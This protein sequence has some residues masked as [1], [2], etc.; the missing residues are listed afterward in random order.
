MS[1]TFTCGVSLGRAGPSAVAVTGTASGAFVVWEDFECVRM[2]PGV[3]GK[4]S[5]LRELL[6]YTNS[7][8][9]RT[10]FCWLCTSH[11]GQ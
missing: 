3:H 11:G 8:V 4:S 5:G 7:N 9:P 1:Q 2:V 10:G 6:L